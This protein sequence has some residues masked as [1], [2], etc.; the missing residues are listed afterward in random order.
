M[1]YAAMLDSVIN[2][3]LDNRQICTNKLFAAL[4]L[5]AH[6]FNGSFLMDQRRSKIVFTLNIGALAGYTASV[7]CMDNWMEIILKDI[8]GNQ[9]YNNL[10]GYFNVNHLTA[11]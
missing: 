7:F 10:I 6:N 2:L 3:E 5:R 8:N 9:F 4:E 11:S 1:L